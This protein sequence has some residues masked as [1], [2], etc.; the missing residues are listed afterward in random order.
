M[1][2]IFT[3]YINFKPAT[4]ADLDTAAEWQID[5]SDLEKTA[6]FVSLNYK[7]K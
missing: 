2:A 7:G 3:Q 4:S 6:G 1:Q 5:D